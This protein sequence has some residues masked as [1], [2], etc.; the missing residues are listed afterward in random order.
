MTDGK[1]FLLET[2]ASIAEQLSY[3]THL[4]REQLV[5]AC[6]CGPSSSPTPPATT[7]L[8]IRS[9]LIALL[10]ILQRDLSISMRRRRPARRRSLD[11]SIMRYGERI[12]NTM[13][14]RM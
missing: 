5:G 7:A 4:P 8:P 11:E 6:C 2:L 14:S 12:V 3:Q 10:S 1:F 9:G 13:N